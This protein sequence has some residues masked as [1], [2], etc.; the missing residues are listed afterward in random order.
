MDTDKSSA[1]TSKTKDPN[2]GF[3]T[4]DDGR[5]IISDKALRGY[6]G[7]DGSD[8]SSSDDDDDVDDE[9]DGTKAVKRGM[10]DDS[11]DGKL[12]VNDI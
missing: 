5:L 7:G 1:K 6:G 3:K 8:S 9:M 10:E 4:A 11:S 12:D 2:R